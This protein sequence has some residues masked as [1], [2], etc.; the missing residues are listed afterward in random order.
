MATDAGA[1]T[2]APSTTARVTSP[3]VDAPSTPAPAG[4]PAPADVL[5]TH[6]ASTTSS[7]LSRLPPLPP[8]D[9]IAHVPT[10]SEQLTDAL[11][12]EKWNGALLLHAQ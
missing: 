2:S 11:S 8:K 3:T 12:F 5:F 10:F 7:T 4:T 1:H 6:T 9:L